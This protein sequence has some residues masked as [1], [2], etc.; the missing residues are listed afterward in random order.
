MNK[1]NRRKFIQSTALTTAGLGLIPHWTIAGKTQ[2]NSMKKPHI[3]LIMTDQHRGDTLGC[4]GNKI[5]KTPNIDSIASDGVCFRNGFSSTPSCTPA[6]AGLLTGLSPWNHGM[7]GYARVARKYKYEM[8]QM[9]RNLGYYTYGIGKM[10]WFPAKSLHGFHGTLVDESGRAE[11]DGFVSDYRDWFKLQAP[12]EDP[13]KT[14]IDWNEHRAGVYQLKE[15]LH[16]TRWTGQ[17]AVQLIQNYKLDKPLF[18][19]VSFARPHSPYDP[20]QRYFDM[21][22]DAEIPRPSV[23]NW[24]AKFADNPKTKDA[25]F[26]DFGAEYAA[27]S[28]KHYYANITFIDD[29]VGEIIHALKEKGMYDDALICFTSD[30]GDMMG[31]HH[32]WRKTYAYQGSANVPFLMKWPKTMATQLSRG[33]QLC[34]PVELRDFLPTF[35]DVAGGE[36]PDDMDGKSLIQLIKNKNPEW[37]HFI[38]L[39]HATCYT[40][41]NYWCALTD[42]KMKYIW[43]FYTGE[44]QLFDLTSDPDEKLNLSG[45]LNYMESL[46]LWRS[47]IIKHLEL[48]GETFVK[49]GKLV[50]R[51]TTMLLSPNYPKEARTE[52]Q[53]LKSWMDEN[54]FKD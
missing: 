33:S 5:I 17:T 2:K 16:P 41:E 50:Q 49:A 31:D 13:D 4:M 40:N 8:P 35:L 18:L 45:E 6:R 15:Q 26:G 51:N 10:H 53:L 3:I 9:L 36:V 32:H 24:A 46:E 38:D 1:I 7:L 11:Q 30:H 39:E 34:Q 37:R 23:G 54:T 21:Y 22:K 52:E 20:P 12:G 48:R 43:F 19:K 44:E 27:N 47:R 14:G 42:G 29:Q 25:A 28:R